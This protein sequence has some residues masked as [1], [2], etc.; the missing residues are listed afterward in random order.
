MWTFKSE[1]SE[2]FGPRGRSDNNACYLCRRSPVEV[3]EAET[4][5]AKNSLRLGFPTLKTD[6]YIW[7]LFLCL[8]IYLFIGGNRSA[9]QQDNKGS[10]TALLQIQLVSHSN[11]LPITLP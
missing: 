5:E 11:S 1:T 4:N 3:V 9:Q 6:E 2:P 7:L 10:G 8:F